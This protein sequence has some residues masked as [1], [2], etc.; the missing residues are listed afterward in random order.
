MKVRN[1]LSL[2]FH[3]PVRVLIQYRS[4][5][6]AGFSSQRRT[7]FYKLTGRKNLPG[8]CLFNYTAFACLLLFAT[9]SAN[10]QNNRGRFTQ[11]QIDSVLSIGSG[12]SGPGKPVAGNGWGGWRSGSQG[13]M[14]MGTDPKP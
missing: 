8:N 7:H 11:Q 3:L 12:V 4:R 2:F 9:M 1:H 14:Y 5:H 10:A 6:D 13:V